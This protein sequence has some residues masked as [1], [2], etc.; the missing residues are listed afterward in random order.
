MKKVN[1]LL[2]MAIFLMG[3]SFTSCDDDSSDGMS[4]EEGETKN[5][6]EI[7]AGS[8]SF[9]TLLAALERV[10]LTATFQDENADYTVFAPT[11]AAF[12]AL[13]D[14]DNGI[15][16]L[17][18]ISDEE[19]TTVLTH[20]VVQGSVMA[21]DL[22]DGQELT[23]LAGTK[24]LVSIE[25]GNVIVGGGVVAEADVEASNGIIHVVN[26]VL[27]PEEP[28]PTIAELVTENENFSTLLSALTTANLAE[29]FADESAS[30]T[31]FAPDNAAFQALLDAD[32]GIN[33]LTD[34]SADQLDRVLKFHVVA[35]NVM[36]S[37]LTDGQMVET[38]SGAKLE[39]KIMDGNVYVGGAMVTTPDVATTN[40]TI[41][42]VGD[43]LLPNTILDVA[44]GSA[45]F[46]VLVD[47]LKRVELAGMFGVDGETK[48][49]VFAP[50]NAAFQALLDVDNGINALTDLSADQLDR[51]L[52]FHVVAGNVMS[53]D[54]TDG[55]MVETLSGAKL[56]VK[57]MDGNVYVGGAMVTTPD[58][59]TTNGTIHIVGDVLLPNTIL[60]VA[61]GNSDFS[62]LVDALKRV[63]LAG[64]FGVDGETKYTV[65][66]PTNA[67]FQALLDVDNGI[68][69]LDDLTDEQLMGVLKYHVV[70]AE[71]LS[72]SLSDGQMIQTL[73]GSEVTVSID[74]STV[75]IDG[76]TVVAADIM[77]SNGVIHVIDQVII[78]AVQ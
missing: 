5:I 61:L 22:S 51:V 31:V 27:L 19:L 32:N 6:A 50:A 13:L 34:L 36:S 21:S 44:L 40:G 64:M 63:E 46:S 77:T 74:G 16:S 59:A 45:A 72:T 12:Q 25:G 35:G 42:I 10:S 53:S 58:V 55:Q 26:S 73:E 56:E 38:L 66:A 67:A 37:D 2:L 28:M 7:V 39:V 65:F 33:A 75:M 71:A 48:Y 68:N 47:A 1:I 18:D 60:D 57:I 23:T 20:H 69:S 43:V 15:N 9:S 54:L 41:H 3:V 62:I 4:P 17:D 78:P 8:S 76:A 70:G 49:T 52:K 30:F 24:L 29:V 11:D 14:A